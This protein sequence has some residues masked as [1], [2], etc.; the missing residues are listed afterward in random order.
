MGEVA[1]PV[2]KVP[3]PR[4]PWPRRAVLTA[5]PLVV[6]VAAWGSAIRIRDELQAEPVQAQ[7]THEHDGP[8]L[9][10]KHCASC[11][12]ERGDGNGIVSLDPKAR[13]FGFERYKFISTTNGVPTDDDLLRVLR[14]G[15]PGSAMYAFEPILSESQMRAIIGHLRE[16]TRKGIYAR[17]RQKAEKDDDYD[18]QEV[19]TKTLAQSEVGPVF[20]IPASFTPPT[21]ESIALGKAAYTKACANCHGPDGKG[22]GPQVKDLK[23]DIGTPAR[24]RDLTRGV[25]KGGGEPDRLYLRLMLGIPGTP[26]PASE[27]TIPRADIDHLIN[28]VKSM[29]NPSRP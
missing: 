13:Y 22:D 16:L 20:P 5:V 10:A 15:I 6:M 2:E 21:A 8:K 18:P 27:T 11:H 25:F 17:L 12:G 9:F 1:G 19:A 4:L 26:M 24:P 29:S 14:H 3:G 7:S 28:Y 23:N